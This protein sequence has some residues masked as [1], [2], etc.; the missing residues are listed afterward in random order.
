ME[1]QISFHRVGI[2]EP[3]FNTI[4]HANAIIVYGRKFKIY[5]TKLGTQQGWPLSLIHCGA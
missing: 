3:G 1:T 5:I 4:E 2:E